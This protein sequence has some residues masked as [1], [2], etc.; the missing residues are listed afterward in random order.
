MLTGTGSTCMLRPGFAPRQTTYPVP[1][2]S[3]ASKAEQ[4]PWNDWKFNDE[5]LLQLVQCPHPMDEA[6]MHIDPQLSYRLDA[7]SKKSYGPLSPRVPVNR[8]SLQSRRV[9]PF[10][11]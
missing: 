2:A 3:C 11:L 9:M 8:F 5:R 10:I 7:P 4:A 1:Q 6:T